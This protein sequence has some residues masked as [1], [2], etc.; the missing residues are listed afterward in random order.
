MTHVKFIGHQEL[1]YMDYV[2]EVNGGV[3]VCRPGGEYHIQAIGFGAVDIPTD[4][5]FA[6]IEDEQDE[7]TE[8]EMFDD[9][10]FSEKTGSQVPLAP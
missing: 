10:V 6:V 2:D 9:E 8:D 5:R 3:L 1:T 7:E 4:G